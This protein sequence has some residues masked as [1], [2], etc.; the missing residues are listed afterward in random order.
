MYLLIIKANTK[1]DNVIIDMPISK[2]K[3]NTFH[4]FKI[5]KPKML[6]KSFLI[7][8]TIRKLRKK[9]FFRFILFHHFR[10][11]KDEKKILKLLI[12]PAYIMRYPN[13]AF[14]EIR[15]EYE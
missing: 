9:F 3:Q 14:Y 13:Y 12:R 15:P 5:P 10:I 7:S 4:L 1:I 11:K 8:S 6:Q 2:S